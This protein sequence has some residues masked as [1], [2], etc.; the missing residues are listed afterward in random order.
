[1]HLLISSGNEGGC[2]SVNNGEVKPLDGLRMTGMDLKPG[3]GF[4]RSIHENCLVLRKQ[5]DLSRVLI[6][7][8]LK[9]IHDVLI[10]DPW[11]YV[12]GTERNAIYRFN[13]DGTLDKTWRFATEP[14][15]WH[16]NCL[17]EINGK[18][19]FTAFGDFSVSRGYK[20]ASRGRGFIQCLESGERVV[21]GLSQPHSLCVHDGK[22]YLANSETGEIFVFNEQ[23]AFLGKIYIGGYL[24]GIA[25]SN[26]CLLVGINSSRNVQNTGD[27]RA[28]IVAVDLSARTIRVVAEMPTLEIYSILSFASAYDLVSGLADLSHTSFAFLSEKLKGNT[29]STSDIKPQMSDKFY[30]PPAPSIRQEP[31]P[32]LFLHLQKTAGTS[33]TAAAAR[34]YGPENVCSHGDFLGKSPDELARFAFVSGHFGFSFAKPL[35][36]NRFSFTFLRSPIERVLSFYYFCRTRDPLEFPTYKIAQEHDLDS[37]LRLAQ[38]NRVIRNRIWNG[39]TW[40][41]CSGPGVPNA[42]VDDLSPE[43]ML[44][45]A[46]A[47]LDAFS[48]VGFTETFNEDVEVIMRGIGMP[49]SMR[50]GRENVTADR[51][52]AKDHPR[53]TIRLIE[54]I[55]ELDQALYD[56]AWQRRRAE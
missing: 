55:T 42:S 30:A 12:A 36:K 50:P 16:L 44:A 24:R 21:S 27:E 7:A 56:A 47:N 35:M 18:I 2:F 22:L 38:D 5:G 48:F 25:F 17:A 46:V 32:S 20:E 10:S 11:I 40:R 13:W 1:M 14:D 43:K 28:K 33:I 31:T 15:A 37:F 6:G 23:F 51:P 4:A 3:V 34:F 29:L 39:Q 45:R 54:E 52:L 19:Y 9:D 8:S 49:D 41:L 53:Q 26:G